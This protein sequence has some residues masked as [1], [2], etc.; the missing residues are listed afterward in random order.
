MKSNES[1]LYF[2]LIGLNLL[3]IPIS[4]EIFNHREAPPEIYFYS[5][6]LIVV[7]IYFVLKKHTSLISKK[8]IF[9]QGLF[10][11]FLL[12]LNMIFCGDIYVQYNNEKNILKKINYHDL[13][14]YGDLSKTDLIGFNFYRYLDMGTRPFF[15]LSQENWITS[16][17]ILT[18]DDK[19]IIKSGISNYYK[20]ERT[21]IIAERLPL[22]LI[23]ISMIILFYNSRKCYKKKVIKQED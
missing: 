14:V 6:L 16:K 9:F 19:S 5:L 23:L 8:Y 15:I 4:L 3:F 11:S 7:F 21:E 10:L 20:K 1:R 18:I 2:I 22:T 13:Y 12:L 17:E